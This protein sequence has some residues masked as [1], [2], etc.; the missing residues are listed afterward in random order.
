MQTISTEDGKTFA[1]VL[2]EESG[3]SVSLGMSSG[4]RVDIPKSRIEERRS[5]RVS[6]MPSMSEALSPQQVADLI[7]FLAK[8]KTETSKPR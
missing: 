3:L 6:A 7:V 8:Q 5:S 2:L 4:E 1:G